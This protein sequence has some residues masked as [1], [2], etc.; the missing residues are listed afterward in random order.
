MLI[1]NS[2]KIINKLIECCIVH[3]AQELDLD[4]HLQY[5]KQT[6]GWAFQL[7]NRVPIEQLGGAVIR[8]F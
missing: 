1:K 2:Q 5:A 8:N 4:R 6:M 3:G 7:S